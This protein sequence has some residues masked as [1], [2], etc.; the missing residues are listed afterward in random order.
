MDGSLTTRVV[1]APHSCIVQ[2]RLYHIKSV[3]ACPHLVQG[4][5][6]GTWR[7]GVCFYCALGEPHGGLPTSFGSWLR[8]VRGELCA[9][10]ASGCPSGVQRRRHQSAWRRRAQTVTQMHRCPW[11]RAA[12]QTLVGRD[13]SESTG[14][15]DSVLRFLPFL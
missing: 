13:G 14:P 8:P 6:T 15:S 11:L 9:L 10:V 1:G 5:F 4:V 7:S 3:L 2:G 12:P